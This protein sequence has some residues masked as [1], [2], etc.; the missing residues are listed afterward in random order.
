MLQNDIEETNFENVIKTNDIDLK[1]DRFYDHLYN[2]Q[3][4]HAPYVMHKPGSQTLPWFS[5][6]IKH[7]IQTKKI[8]EKVWKKS[9]NPSDK[10][11]FDSLSILY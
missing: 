6:D 2:L 10:A 11:I 4:R 7:K 8:A 9:R 1:Y 5:N 3:D